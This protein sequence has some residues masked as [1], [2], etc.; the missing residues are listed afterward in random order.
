MHKVVQLNT[1]KENKNKKI[2]FLCNKKG[3]R[4]IRKSMSK[5]SERERETEPQVWMESRGINQVE[6][7]GVTRDG[8]YDRPS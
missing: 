2:F 5:R 8:P 7:K 4:E 6:W 3:G 1:R